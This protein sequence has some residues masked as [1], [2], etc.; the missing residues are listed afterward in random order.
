MDYTELFR[1]IFVHVGH[2]VLNLSE[3]ARLHV[4]PAAIVGELQAMLQDVFRNPAADRSDFPRAWFPLRAWLDERLRGLPGGDCLCGQLVQAEAGAE[5][6]FFR[7]LNLLLAAPDAEELVRV[8]ATCLELGFRGYYAR[9]GFEREL[10]GYRARCREYLTRA[11]SRECDKTVSPAR[12]QTPVR[13][14]ARFATRAAPVAATVLL[15]CLYRFLLSDLYAA[16]V[17]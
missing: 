9:P 3:P 4:S 6:E 11:E 2:L 15:Y 10:A 12:G 14:A 1:P 7:R 5:S 17:G 8:Y 16:V 13:Y